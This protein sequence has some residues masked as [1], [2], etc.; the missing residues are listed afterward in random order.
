MKKEN[1]S[2]TDEI[3][4]LL[5]STFDLIGPLRFDF[6]KLSAKKSSVEVS[7]ESENFAVT[8]RLERKKEVK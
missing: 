4:V 5:N 7:N 8:M 6:L 3:H 1:L 2:E